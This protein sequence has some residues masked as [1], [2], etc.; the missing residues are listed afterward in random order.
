MT[1]ER[2]FDENAPISPSEI[3]KTMGFCPEI[4]T[5]IVRIYEA[6]DKCHQK[7]TD[8]E[9]LKLRIGAIE[10]DIDALT[11]SLD[12]VRSVIA[13]Q[14]RLL[15]CN[16]VFIGTV[17]LFFQRFISFSPDPGQIQQTVEDI[18]DNIGTIPVTIG[19]LNFMLLYPLWHAG[20]HVQTCSI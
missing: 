3:D 20:V 7:H 16:R 10:E 5:L 6:R 14:P 15:A 9:A 12:A 18:V 2:I 19:A 13:S 11:R 17:R 4:L 1:V 8:P